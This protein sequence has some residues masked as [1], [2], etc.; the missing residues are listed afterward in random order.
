MEAVK[1]LQNFDAGIDR[2]VFTSEDASY[3]EAAKEYAQVIRIHSQ[4]QKRVA[5]PVPAVRDIQECCLA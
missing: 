4:T 5:R 2:V 1:Y 3:I